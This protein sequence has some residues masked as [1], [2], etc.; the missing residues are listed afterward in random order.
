MEILDYDPEQYWNSSIQ[1]IDTV[2]TPYLHCLFCLQ[3]YQWTC[4]FLV[5]IHKSPVLAPDEKLKG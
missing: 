4:D 5:P 3:S 1:I 2:S